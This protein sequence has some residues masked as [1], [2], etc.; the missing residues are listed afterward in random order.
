MHVQQLTDAAPAKEP[1]AIDSRHDVDR[2]AR[3]FRV[4]NRLHI[5]DFLATDSAAALHDH[6]VNVVDWSY[7]LFNNKHLWEV[8][9]AARQEYTAEQDRNVVDLAYA[10]AQDGYSFLYEATPL[11]A[12]REGGGFTRASHTSLLKVFEGF[13]DSEPFLEFARRLTGA[14]DIGWVEATGTC[15]R[16][17]HFLAPHDDSAA[18]SR[19]VA[20]VFNMTKTWR[21]EWGGLLEFLDAHGHVAEGY[22]PR[23]NSFNLFKV[24]QAHLVSCVAPFA[25]VPRVAVSGWFHAGTRPERL[26]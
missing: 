6:L 21:P 2:L 16:P 12:R 23:F 17:G 20:Y 5:P 14:A 15:F 8:P 4:N 25:P 24:P 22:V 19:R 10:A 7:F 11:A 18:S 9:A 26:A 13:L 3:A 1:F